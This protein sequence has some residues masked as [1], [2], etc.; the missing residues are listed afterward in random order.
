MFSSRDRVLYPEDRLSGF[1]AVQGRR[2]PVSGLTPSTDT[3]VG[4]SVEFLPPLAV[5]HLVVK[6]SCI[7]VETV[8]S[9]SI[10]VNEAQLEILFPNANMLLAKVHLAIRGENKWLSIACEV[11]VSLKGV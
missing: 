8:P 10:A 7:I 3:I 6:C 4:P 9:R 11:K 5:I 1:A 2:C